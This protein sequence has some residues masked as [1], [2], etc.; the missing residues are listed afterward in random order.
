M[1][2]EKWEEKLKETEVEWVKIVE[3]YRLLPSPLFRVLKL[4]HTRP[5][6]QFRCDPNSGNVARDCDSGNM[7][8]DSYLGTILP[9]ICIA[10]PWYIVI[11][12]KLV[13]RH[14]QTWI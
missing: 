12:T 9:L 3:Q 5:N 4:G 8:C 14:W 1:R 10:G 13:G 2:T 7:L 11:P 6:L